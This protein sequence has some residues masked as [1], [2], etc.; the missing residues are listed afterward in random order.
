MQELGRRDGEV[1]GLQVEERGLAR[2]VIV[3]QRGPR[4]IAPLDSAVAG[5]QAEVLLARRQGEALA[6]ELESPA[7]PARWVPASCA[8]ARA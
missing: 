1:R 3:A 2:G 4:L 8:S 7:T 5:L 6:Q